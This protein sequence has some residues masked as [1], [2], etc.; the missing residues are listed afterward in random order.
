MTNKELLKI[1]QKH[2]GQGG[3]VFRKFCGLPS[4][5]AWCN[6]FVDYVAKEGGVSALYFNGKKE[7]YCPH[8][9]AW[10]KKNLAQ[11]PL[12]LAMPMDII[13]FDWDRNGNP[14]HIGFVRAKK[15][16]SS[17]YTI[18]GNT[19]GGRVAQKTRAGKY[20]QAV[21]RPHFKGAF[22]LQKLSVDGDCGYSTIANLQ[23]ALGGT[24]VDGVLGIATVKRLQQFVA[25]GQDGQWGV[26]T[27]KAVQKM[28]KANK[29]YSGA[30][31]GDFG[32][33]S[34]K[35][36]QTWINKKLYSAA[37]K[38][39]PQPTPQPTPKPTKKGY[40][41]AFPVLPT[42]TAKNAVSF[43]Y[44]YGTKLKVYKYDGGH[45]K[46]NYKNA[47]KKYYPK[48]SRWGA[49]ARAG[50]S[51]DVFVGT[52]LRAS[53]YSKA[54]RGLKEQKSW[55]GKNLTR[56]KSIRNGDILLRSNHVAVFLELKGGKYVAN[57]HHEKNG[58]TYGIIEKICKYDKAYRP[59][60]NSYFSKGDTFTQVKALQKF[61]NWF[62]GYK[63][64]ED[65]IFGKATE[66]AVKDF[67]KKM[68]LS[69]T[70][71]FGETEL[72]K[73]KAYKR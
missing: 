21:Y 59:G 64:A 3:A 73:A 7:T 28:L 25:V 54:P 2:I 45:P 8:S 61:L 55:L 41:G 62:G 22:K 17:I 46:E 37:P 32:V 63:L 13:Y 39:T 38:P 5:A 49:K 30:I 4:G 10:C 24:S 42:K 20:V 31:D 12:Y 57:A 43:A 67:Q 14:N 11:V 69:V 6:A 60:G 18:E 34:V 9:I 50:A 71:R 36:L 15:D 27:S 23:K 29:C 70:G 47:L 52:D 65:Y 66:N 19:D 16:T 35:G 40:T 48:R 26:G 58:G 68:G 1:A 44:A 72:K 33:N 53:G 56:V 51:C